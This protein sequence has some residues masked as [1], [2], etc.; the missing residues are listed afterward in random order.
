PRGERPSIAAVPSQFRAS[1]PG[2][3][4][5]RTNRRTTMS[6]FRLLAGALLAVFILGTALAPASAGPAPQQP[7][8]QQPPQQ[9]APPLAPPKP[10]KVVPITL[11]KPMG[12]ASHAAFLKQ[13]A[14]IAQ[15]KDKA[16]LGRLIAKDFFWFPDEKDVA[17]KRKSGIENLS[18]ALG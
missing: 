17:D 7:P 5:R 9:Q 15:K 14:G 13:L 4:N 18:K 2:V 8:Q 11:P 1:R 6:R 3:R 12:D 10:Y 16:A